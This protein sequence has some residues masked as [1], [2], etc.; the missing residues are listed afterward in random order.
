M[1]WR[2]VLMHLLGLPCVQRL[3]PE[4]PS[5]WGLSACLFPAPP[6]IHIALQVI[7]GG[8]DFEEQEQEAQSPDDLLLAAAHPVAG[9]RHF[10]QDSEERSWTWGADVRVF[11]WT[12][13]A[14]LSRVPGLIYLHPAHAPSTLPPPRVRLIFAGPTTSG[15]RHSA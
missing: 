15:P 6:G 9:K 10:L 3:L 14:L 13:S 12:V 8:L 4:L 5:T 2:Q 11:G 1:V 7:P